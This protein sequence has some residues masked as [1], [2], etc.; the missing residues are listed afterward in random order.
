MVSVSEI[1]RLYSVLLPN[2]HTLIHNIKSHP[3]DFFFF[4]TLKLMAVGRKKGLRLTVKKK[5]EGEEQRGKE[6]PRQ[7]GRDE[8]KAPAEKIYEAE[9]AVG[10]REG[11]QREVMGGKRKEERGPKREESK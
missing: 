8:E 7:N 1:K 6:Q 3:G 2:T 5:E 10:E 11:N 9:Y 4:L